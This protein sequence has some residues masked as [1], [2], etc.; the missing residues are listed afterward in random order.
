LFADIK[1]PVKRK[2]FKLKFRDMADLKV[3]PLKMVLWVFSALFGNN[4][5]LSTSFYDILK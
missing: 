4:T 5:L 2:D 1:K 3:L